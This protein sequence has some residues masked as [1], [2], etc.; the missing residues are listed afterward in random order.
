[1]GLNISHQLQSFFNTIADDHNVLTTYSPGFKEQ[2]SPQQQSFKGYTR[3]ND[4]TRQTTDTPGFKYQ[5]PRLLSHGDIS[6][7]A[8]R[9]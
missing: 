3:P 9:H 2:T 1:M 4:C 8:R 5:S 7:L 6:T